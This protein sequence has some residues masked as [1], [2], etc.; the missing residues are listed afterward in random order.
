M[1]FS[2]SNFRGID[3][4]NRCRGSLSQNMKIVLKF[5]HDAI[6]IEPG[7]LVSDR[8]WV[9][10]KLSQRTEQKRVLA[11]EAV[12]ADTTG[13]PATLSLVVLTFGVLLPLTTLPT[14]FAVIT[15]ERKHSQ[16]QGSDYSQKPN[17]G[18][19]NV[20]SLIPHGLSC[21]PDDS[22]EELKKNRREGEQ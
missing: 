8:G 12:A 18:S 9:P 21:G 19:D 10:Y 16:P 1:I 11:M 4:S 20:D 3:V 14:R 13:I 17:D 22:D 2:L 7:G 15:G 6:D 5:A